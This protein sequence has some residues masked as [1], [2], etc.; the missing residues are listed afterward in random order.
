MAKSRSKKRAKRVQK[1]GITKVQR[2]RVTRKPWTNR[3]AVLDNISAP[4]TIGTIDDKNIQQNIRVSRINESS[5]VFKDA[6]RDNTT[7]KVCN[8]RRKRRQILFSRGKAGAGK[9]GPKRRRY[10]EKSKVRC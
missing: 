1:R 10:T 4:L 2:R 5:I 3:F 7:R 9:R 8:S 6:L